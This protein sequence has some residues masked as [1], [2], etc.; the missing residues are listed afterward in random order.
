MRIIFSIIFSLILLFS[1]TFAADQPFELPFDGTAFI[2]AG[3]NDILEEKPDGTKITAVESYVDA[4]DEGLG[5]GLVKILSLLY[6]IGDIIAICIF[7]FFG[8]KY[9]VATPQKK[10]DLKASMYPY[11]VGLLLYIAGVP[12]AISI[13]NIFINVF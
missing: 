3:K 5:N 12:I 2:E 10:A 11:F 13:I 7:I 1:T 4:I 8:L 9:L 6:Q